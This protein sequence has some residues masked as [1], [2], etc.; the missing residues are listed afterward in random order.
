MNFK[1]ME[2]E[3]TD[4][5]LNGGCQLPA[6]LGE[7]DPLGQPASYMGTPGRP[8]ADSKSRKT[9]LYSKNTSR[10]RDAGARVSDNGERC[11]EE[12]VRFGA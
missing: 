11:S 2:Q 10:S 3:K 6:A 8:S 9:D 12:W 1:V 7:T 4:V 5:R